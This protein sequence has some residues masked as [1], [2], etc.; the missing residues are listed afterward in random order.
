LTCCSS[1]CITAGFVSHQ[2]VNIP[3]IHLVTQYIITLNM[4]TRL[5]LLGG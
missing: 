3:Q 2:S 5:R 1:P 4:S